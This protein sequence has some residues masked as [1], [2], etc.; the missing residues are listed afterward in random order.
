MSLI[1]IKPSVEYIEEIKA[2]QQ[3]FWNGDSQLFQGAG[4]IRQTDDAA[5]WIVKCRNMEIHSYAESLGLVDAE[6]YMLVREGE[7]RILG[8]INFRHYLNDYLAE[9]A[10]H[11]GYGVR[12]SERYGFLA[13]GVVKGSGFGNAQEVRYRRAI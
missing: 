1:L 12:P 6:Q 11:I 7:K 3:E 10:G 13:D 5:E 2:Y 9:Y 4:G 8:M